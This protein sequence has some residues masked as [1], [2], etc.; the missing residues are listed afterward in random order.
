MVRFQKKVVD[1]APLKI[2]AQRAQPPFHRREI[3]VVAKARLE[4]QALLARLIEIDFPR[5]KIED[6]GL[7][8][9]R[10]HALEQPARQAVRHEPKVTAAACRQVTVEKSH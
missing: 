4:A 10:N 5:M 2:A 8:V 3:D 7:A 9:D 6:A 1:P